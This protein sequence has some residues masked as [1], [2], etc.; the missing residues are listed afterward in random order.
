MAHIGRAVVSRPVVAYWGILEHFVKGFY[1]NLGASTS[2][3][4]ELWDLVLGLHS[5]KS[6]AVPSLIAKLD[7][8]VVVNMVSLICSLCRRLQS[9]LDEAL[10]LV[11]SHGWLCSIHHVYHEANRNANMLANLGH[12]GSFQ[13][14]LIARGSHMLSLVIDAD[15]QGVLAPWIVVI[16]CLVIFFAWK[17]NIL[18]YKIFQ[19]LFILTL[20]YSI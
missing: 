3:S 4:A 9:L 13:W 15:I 6:L 2:V 1:C 7:F 5:A 16:L 18:K 20:I 14:T 8:K 11:G 12:S 19:Y 17:K 10:L